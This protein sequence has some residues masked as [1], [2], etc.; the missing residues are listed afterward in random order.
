LKKAIIVWLIGWLKLE[1]FLVAENGHFLLALSLK[2][3]K[4]EGMVS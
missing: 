4:V 2:M 1:V 3:G